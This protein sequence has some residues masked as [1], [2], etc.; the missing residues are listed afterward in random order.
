MVAD[1]MMEDKVYC[2]LTPPPQ[3]N[4]DFST[5]CNTDFKSWTLKH[6]EYW[7][8]N[9]VLDWLFYVA[10]EC[11]MEYSRLA[12]EQF[13]TVTGTDMVRMNQKDWQALEPNY[14]DKLHS[15]FQNLL[16]KNKDLTPPQPFDV[17]AFGTHMNLFIKGPDDIDMEFDNSGYSTPPEDML[18]LEP[19]PAHTNFNFA[20]AYHN[21]NIPSVV[22][23]AVWRNAESEVPVKKTK[24]PGRPPKLLKNGQPAK[25]RGRRPGQP[26][27]CMHLWEFILGLLKDSKYNPSHIRWENHKEGIFR[28]V[29]SAQVATMWG[30][31]KKNKTM[32]YEKLSRA[33]RFCRSS[34]VFADV[35]REGNYP[36]KLCFRFGPKATG[37]QQV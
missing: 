23:D 8:K 3:Y 36:K 15:C 33:M 32:N 28:I 27:K 2:D 14:G 18:A 22:T 5:D 1:E 37:W 7:Q 30:E 19:P 31:K 25:P 12:A 11:H 10:Q 17:D 20:G 13:N 16:A 26:S 4:K 21:D 6:P 24:G 34:E 35:P 29:Q 9:E